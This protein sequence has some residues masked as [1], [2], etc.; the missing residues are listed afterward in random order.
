M[1][2]YFLDGFDWRAYARCP[3]FFEFFKSSFEVIN[4][5][6]GQFAKKTIR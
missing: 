2:L 5:D 3:S 4:P 1:S 6:L